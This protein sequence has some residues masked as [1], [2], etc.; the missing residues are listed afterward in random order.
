MLQRRHGRAVVEMVG[1]RDD[2][3]VG[4]LRPIEHVL[5]GDEAMGVGD[6]EAQVVLPLL[7]NDLAEVLRACAHGRLDDI[8]LV[9][10]HDAAVAVVLA[11]RGYPEHPSEPA[12]V[13]GLGTAADLGCTVFHGGTKLSG[14]EVM[15][16]GGRVLA[17]TAVTSDLGTAAELAHAGAAAIE[18]AGSH[19]R[20]DIAR[21]TAQVAR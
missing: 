9:W 12:V 4:E 10:S 2:A 15:A 14:G 3:H 8:D 17:V 21:A 7:R 19:H 5:P 6:P 16:V 1:G 13:H 11:S 18:F 20:T